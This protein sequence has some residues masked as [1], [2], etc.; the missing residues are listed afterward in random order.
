MGYQLNYFAVFHNPGF[1]FLIVTSDTFPFGSRVNSKDDIIANDIDFEKKYNI[2]IK[3]LTCNYSKEDK[4]WIWIKDIRKVIDE[5]K[6]DIIYVHGVESVTAMRIVFSGLNKKHL[7]VS[8]THSLL[9]QFSNNLKSKLFL[10]FIKNIYSKL[11]NRKEILVFSTADENEMMLKELYKFNE[12][13]V[14]SSLIGTNLDDYKFDSVER[15]N[16][17]SNCK[18]LTKQKYYYIRGS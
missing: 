18:F 7:I 17:K 9:N 1:E 14:K 6:P 4:H 16:I 8:D 2:R 5:I 15:E 10:S 3:R 11:I 13:N 12:N